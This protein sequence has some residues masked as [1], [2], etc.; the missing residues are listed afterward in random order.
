MA[1]GD[2]RRHPRHWGS[3]RAAQ[4]PLHER[5]VFAAAAA[6]GASRQGDVGVNVNVNASSCRSR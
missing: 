5:K 6:G 4:S 3:S 1:S 2:V